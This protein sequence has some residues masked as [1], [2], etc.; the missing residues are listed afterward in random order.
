MATEGE[1]FAACLG[2]TW[3]LAFWALI[4]SAGSM[5]VNYHNS[6]SA[7]QAAGGSSLS[8]LYE[9]GRDW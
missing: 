1:Q 3:L 5:G 9:L 6:F 7:Y 8:G 4:V 2:C